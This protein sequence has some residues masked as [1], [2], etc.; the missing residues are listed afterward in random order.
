VMTTSATPTGPATPTDPTGPA[1]PP[2]FVVTINGASDLWDPNDTSNWI[3]DD[4]DN[5]SSLWWAI[6][7]CLCYFLIGALFFC[8][9]EGWTLVDAFYFATCTFATVGYGD[10]KP[11]TDGG[12][13][14][15]CVYMIVGI[16]VISV[17]SIRVSM[18][19][20][21]A[22]S[23]A[24]N[25]MAFWFHYWGAFKCCHAR[26]VHDGHRSDVLDVE[27]NGGGDLLGHDASDVEHES[28]A[29][30][31]HEPTLKY[32]IAR[33]MLALVCMIG[34]GTVVY[35]GF[36]GLSFVDGIYMSTAT[37]ATVGYGDISPSTQ[38][39]RAF[40]MFWI[41]ASYVIILDS[42]HDVLDKSHSETLERKRSQVLNNNLSVR[43]R[44]AGDVWG[45]GLGV[46]LM[47][48]FFPLF[49]FREVPF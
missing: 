19:C 49:M 24:F 11:L 36:E 12:K 44:K 14:F 17:A 21:N 7:Q 30:A 1:T 35:C 42:L 5:S 3:P 28:K 13:L 38:G 8:N 15:A 45:W 32:L 33:M 4:A 20:F 16:S 18:A 40:A 29:V 22:C 25:E 39:G 37:V 9:V 47:L 2:Q 10:V 6:L 23:C 26:Q 41:V 43:R 27:N 48:F 46:G 31:V 34:L